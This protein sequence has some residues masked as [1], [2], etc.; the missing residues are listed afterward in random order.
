MRMDQ[1]QLL[2]AREVVNT[3]T[4]ADLTRIL[5]EYGE[6]RY[7]G[8]IAR[9][10][11]KARQKKPVETTLELADLV[12]SVLP[13]KEL[14]KKGHPAKKTFQAL[15]IETND[16]LGAL[17]EGLTDAL[18]MLNTGGRCAVITFHSLEDRMV[19]NIFKDYSTAPFVE[20]KIPLKAEQR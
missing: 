20:P 3:Y 14:R 7:A 15:R 17:R 2:T 16:E 12:K 10:I 9:G 11:V 6:E 13:A 1:R 18:E 5:R 8:L 4:A 19:K